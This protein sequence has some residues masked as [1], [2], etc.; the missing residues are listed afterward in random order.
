LIISNGVGFFLASAANSTLTFV[1]QVPQGAISYNIPTGLSTLANKVP[2][3]TNFPGATVGNDFDLMY[4]WNQ[5]GQ[6]WGSPSGYYG[7]DLS[8]NG[9][10]ANPSG[11]GFVL[12][13]GDAVFYLNGGSALPFTQNF[14]VN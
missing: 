2:V 13:P 11:N 9:W 1:G 14:T 8:G 4:P 12:N 10:D 5:A 7:T 3:T 6:Q